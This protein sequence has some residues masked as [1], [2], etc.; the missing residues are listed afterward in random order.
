MFRDWTEFET[1]HC[2]DLLAKEFQKE[3]E[4]NVFAAV[5]ESDEPENDSVVIMLENV[6]LRNSFIIPQ[7][8]VS[9]SLWD[10]IDLGNFCFVR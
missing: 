1:N 9:I 6:S 2:R 10:H 8:T 5:D 7:K 3:I 4:T